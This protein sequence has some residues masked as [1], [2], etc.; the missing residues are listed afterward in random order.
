MRKL[1][2]AR[3]ILIRVGLVGGLYRQV[4]QVENGSRPSESWL[5]D[6]MHKLKHN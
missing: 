3:P 5:Q 1:L 4:G 2:R 6:A